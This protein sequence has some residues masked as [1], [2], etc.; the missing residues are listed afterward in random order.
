MSRD[1]DQQ[2][3]KKRN[4]IVGTANYMAPETLRAEDVSVLMDFWSLGVLAFEIL[5]GILPFNAEEAEQVFQNIFSK[6]IEYPQVG[7]EEGQ[8]T[9]EA[10]DLL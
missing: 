3:S 4:R 2:Q 1:A 5:T 6:E 8:V 7:T 9:E 10:L